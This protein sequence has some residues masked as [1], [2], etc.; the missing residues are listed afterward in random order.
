MSQRIIIPGDSLSIETEGI[1]T[2]I[3]PGI[4]KNPKS[5]K[6]IPS[7]AG[8][9]NVKV[10]KKNTNQVVYTDSN[11][12]RYIPQA[13]DF[14]IGIVVGV[15]GEQYKIQLQEYS[16][17]VLLSMMAFPNATKKNRPNLKNGQAVYAR[18]SQAIPEIDIE[19]EC[20]DP[21]TGKDG[22]FGLLDESGYIFD[23]NLN[24]ARELLF[25]P[26]NIFLETLASRCQFEIAIGINGKIWIKCGDGLKIDKDET[27]DEKE[28]DDEDTPRKVDTSNSYLKDLKA[29]LAAARF[30]TRCQ[31]IRPE[32]LDNELTEAFRAN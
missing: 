13:N 9:L 15:I 4:Y 3:G 27:K 16:T 29:T 31:F 8:I 20:I 26:S 5:Q 2:S 7:S 12:K 23:V 1:K 21:V 6:V 11:S 19:I 14:V 24:F 10:N 30:L 32:E 25:N 22:G 28:D 18:V 17:N